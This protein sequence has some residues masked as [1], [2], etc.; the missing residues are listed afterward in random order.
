MKTY[1][2]VDLALWTVLLLVEFFCTC[3]VSVRPWRHCYHALSV[4]SNPQI[5]S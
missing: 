2:Y 4:K 3:K 5:N 1:H